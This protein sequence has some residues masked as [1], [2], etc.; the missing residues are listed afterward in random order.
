MLPHFGI[1][2]NIEAAGFGVPRPPEI[3]G[4]FPQPLNLKGKIH[5]GGKCA[6]MRLRRYTAGKDIFFFHP[7]VY[8]DELFRTFTGSGDGRIIRLEVKLEEVFP[9]CLQGYAPGAFSPLFNFV[10]SP[11]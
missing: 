2:G 10:I 11:G 4:E 6:K 7:V 3:I 9:V 1:E 8:Q 5:D